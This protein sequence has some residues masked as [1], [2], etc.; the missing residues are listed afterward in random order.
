MNFA[1]PLGKS[2]FTGN[3]L[4]LIFRK[5]NIKNFSLDQYCWHAIFDE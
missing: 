5:I 1:K 3:P 4:L 2:F